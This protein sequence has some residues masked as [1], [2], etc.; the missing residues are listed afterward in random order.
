MYDAMGLLYIGKNAVVRHIVG[1]CDADTD[2]RVQWRRG[3]VQS[4]GRAVE[5]GWGVQ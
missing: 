2:T 4:R 5:E 3:G 1:Y